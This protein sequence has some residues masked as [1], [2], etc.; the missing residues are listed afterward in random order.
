MFPETTSPPSGS[1]GT[2]QPA[3]EGD[4]ADASGP[5]ADGGSDLLMEMGTLV[6][7]G[8]LVGFVALVR[9]WLVLRSRQPRPGLPPDRVL[10]LSP[11]ARLHDPKY[12]GRIVD[13]DEPP[14]EA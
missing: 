7:L 11:H 2:T 10:P 13:L 5:A 8:V 1:T 14:P 9:R 3:Q 4:T 12:L 6:V